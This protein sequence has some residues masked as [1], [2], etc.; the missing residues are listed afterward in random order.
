MGWQLALAWL[1]AFLAD[2]SGLIT[3]TIRADRPKTR[4]VIAFDASVHGGG[5]LMWIFP[6]DVV[7]D[8]TVLDATPPW[9]ASPT[10]H[11]GQPR[12]RENKGS[13]GRH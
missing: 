10:P 2:G 12:A 1:Q 8:A 6:A 5:A 4:P 11:P 13:V 3:R 7:I 9:A